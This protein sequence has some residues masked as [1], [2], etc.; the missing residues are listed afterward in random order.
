MKEKFYRL[1]N[2]SP[3]IC[4]KKL[5]IHLSNLRFR[6]VFML[7]GTVGLGQRTAA[8]LPGA[9]RRNK[10]VLGRKLRGVAGF[11]GLLLGVRGQTLS[12]RDRNVG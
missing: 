2:V 9:L 7:P 1:I 6:G 4:M 12:R 5:L 3:K 10:P 11:K 8:G